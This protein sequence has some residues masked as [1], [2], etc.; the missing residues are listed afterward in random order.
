MMSFSTPIT[1]PSLQRIARAVL[2]CIR[3][4]NFKEQEEGTKQRETGPKKKG[5]TRMQ[6]KKKQN[7][8]KNSSPAI[9]NCFGGVFNLKHSTIRRVGC[10]RQI[11]LQKRRKGKKK[12]KLGE[13]E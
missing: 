12:K 2:V 6:K 3:S 4:V 9:V 11:V 7:K 5:E 8:G 1:I 10:A 13:G